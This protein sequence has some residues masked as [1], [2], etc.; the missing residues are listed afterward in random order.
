MHIVQ[1][2]DSGNN[3]KLP[4]DTIRFDS[5]GFSKF[6]YRGRFGFVFPSFDIAYSGMGDT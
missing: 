2:K 3:V 5:H 1:P 4:I 6:V